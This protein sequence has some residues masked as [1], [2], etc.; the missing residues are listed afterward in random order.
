[1]PGH[2]V[3]RRRLVLPAQDG[4][5]SQTLGV[6]VVA[7][8]GRC[9]SGSA[10]VRTS[11]IEVEA[12]LMLLHVQIFGGDIDARSELVA[13]HVGERELMTLRD[14]DQLRRALPV[15]DQE[16]NAGHPRTIRISQA[17]QSS[18][19]VHAAAWSQAIV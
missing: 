16:V 2:D 11:G 15:V 10:E 8:P 12:A 1:K 9:R 17:D 3:S 18:H 13:D 7:Y 14:V 5:E 4:R 19:G 6:D